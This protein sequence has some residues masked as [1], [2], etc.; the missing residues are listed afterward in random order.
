MW[1]ILIDAETEHNRESAVM[2]NVRPHLDN[3]E[4]WTDIRVTSLMSVGGRV[5]WAQVRFF[6]FFFNC[7]YFL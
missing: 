2:L 3:V 6:F 7:I 5:S 4:L 1:K